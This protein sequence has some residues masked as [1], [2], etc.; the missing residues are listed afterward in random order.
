LHKHRAK[1]HQVK[2]ADFDRRFLASSG[3]SIVFWDIHS[4]LSKLA[5]EPVPF[6][7]DLDCGAFVSHPADQCRCES[8]VLL[9]H[10]GHVGT[11]TDF[12]WNHVAPWTVI[13]ASDDAEPFN[14][15]QRNN[16][17]SLQIFRPLQLLVSESGATAAG[18]SQQRPEPAPSDR[19]PK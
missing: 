6:G 7:R 4:D 2:F 14:Q 3:D 12:E 17:S 18:S 15:I 10:I 9:S 13:S 11:V 1:V 16:E 5:T 19:L 8:Q